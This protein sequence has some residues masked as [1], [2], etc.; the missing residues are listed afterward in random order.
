MT[1]TK[2]DDAQ[3]CRAVGCLRWSRRYPADGHGFLCGFHWMQRATKAERAV[4]RRIW[5]L[6]QKVPD[7][8]WRWRP[9]IGSLDQ[10]ERR[11]WE[12]L[13]RRVA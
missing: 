12:A 3:W 7:P 13:V 2:P 10:R 8:W 4:L 6:I 9:G 1:R 5:R 11:C